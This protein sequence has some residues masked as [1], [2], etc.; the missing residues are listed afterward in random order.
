MSTTSATDRGLAIKEAPTSI[1]DMI[2]DLN[3]DDDRS[4]FRKKSVMTWDKKKRNYVQHQDTEA[5]KKELKVRNESGQLVIVGDKDRGKLYKQWSAK[6]HKS[7]PAAGE[8][9]GS[10]G[11]RNESEANSSSSSMP[12]QSFYRHAKHMNGKTA[13][14]IHAA[15]KGRHGGAREMP[16]QEIRSLEQL[17]KKRAAD[18][19]KAHLQSKTGSGGKNKGRR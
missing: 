8:F 5:G 18:A 9:V 1:E 4:I 10:Y 3:P 13:Q 16:K 2:L 15:R 17:R 19:K 7:I 12:Q 14:D 11:G 6:T